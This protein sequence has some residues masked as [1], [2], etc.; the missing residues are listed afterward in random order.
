MRLFLFLIAALTLVSCS[1]PSMCNENGYDGTRYRAVEHCRT[2]H[3][4]LL[5]ADDYAFKLRHEELCFG[6]P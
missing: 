6:K 4:C 3:Q 1:V 2:T 5:N